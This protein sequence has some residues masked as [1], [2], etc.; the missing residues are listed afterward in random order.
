MLT[1]VFDLDGTLI[2]SAPDLQDAVNEILD[3]EGVAPIGEAQTRLM[4]GHGARRL[5]E[6]A[7]ATGGRILSEEA[8]ESR[9]SEFLVQYHQNSVVRTTLFPGA[10]EAVMGLKSKGHRIALCT[11]KP[12]SLAGQVCE[13]LGIIHLFDGFVGARSLPNKKPFPEPVWHA[14]EQ[15]GGERAS[16]VMVG[17]TYVDVAA[18]KA[19]GIPS[20]AVAWGYSACGGQHL[21]ADV[22]IHRFEALE[23]VVDA[24]WAAQTPMS[25]GARPSASPELAF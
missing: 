13:H 8:L 15:A 9:I 25:L 19:A 23:M 24:L 11:N 22:L 21:G 4:L 16:A 1:V 12:V 3:R 7:L 20:V 10:I 17:D 2:D 18:A 6:R 5:L 14:I